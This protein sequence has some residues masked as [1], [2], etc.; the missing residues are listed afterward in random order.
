[1]KTKFVLLS[2][3][4]LLIVLTL[5]ILEQTTY[6]VK[7]NTGMKKH[8][9]AAMMDK[10]TA[11]VTVEGTHMKVWVITQ[12]QHK[13]MMKSM[14]HDGMMKKD[15]SIMMN[16]NMKGMKHDGMDMDK[17]MKGAMMAGTHH[18]MLDVTDAAGGTNIS[19]AKINAQIASPSKKNNTVELKSMMNH[20]GVALTLDEKGKYKIIV[21][22]V[23]AG[24]TK[25]F[26]FQ[27]KV[28]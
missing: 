15:S 14:K 5:T 23:V 27:Y 22:V 1:M 13:K 3:T 12:K 2:T 4:I 9:I 19:T 11:D 21:N 16:K 28:K 25:T 17:A 18:I 7:A 26:E 8:D 6:T 10:P 20:Y 24:K